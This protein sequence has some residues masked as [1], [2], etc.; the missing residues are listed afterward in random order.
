MQS[1]C[2]APGSALQ[3]GADAATTPAQERSA[4][5]VASDL[6]IDVK[7]AE[8]LFQAHVDDVFR[9]VNVDV[10]E[11]RVLLTGVVPT[12]ERVTESGEIAAGIKGVRTVINRLEAGDLSLVDQTRDRGIAARLR[13][14]LLVDR[15]VRNVNYTIAVV[16][17][18]VHILGIAQDEAERRRVAAHARDIPYVREAVLHVILKDDSARRGDSS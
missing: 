14:R 3:A 16:D 5:D 10:F 15:A 18:V 6:L 7:I 9:P 12:A 11:G 2:S 1:A 13:G 8:A 17:S 4:G